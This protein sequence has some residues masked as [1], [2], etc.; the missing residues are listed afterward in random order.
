LADT[1]RENSL[2]LN[3][4]SF[5]M[6]RSTFHAV[7]KSMMLNWSRLASASWTDGLT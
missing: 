4:R 2:R 6:I 1:R 5:L 7:V 3:G